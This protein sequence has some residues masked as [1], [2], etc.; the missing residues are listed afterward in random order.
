MSLV[1]EFANTIIHHA[2]DEFELVHIA[3]NVICRI[4]WF[5]LTFG[6]AARLLLKH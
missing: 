4:T 1:F 6:D 5:W 2:F 3:L